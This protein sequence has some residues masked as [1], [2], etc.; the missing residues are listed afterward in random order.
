[1]L[2][3]IL[4][5]ILSQSKQTAK[6][7]QSK[8]NLRQIGLAIQVYATSYDDVQPYASTTTT[9]FA[10]FYG[11]RIY[12]DPYYSM[13][14]T[15]LLSEVLTLDRRIFRAPFDQGPVYEGSPS[16]FVSSWESIHLKERWITYSYADFPPLAAIP[17]SAIEPPAN[18]VLVSEISHQRRNP[19][20][21]TGRINCLFYDLSVRRE[22]WQTCDGS[23]PQ[24][25]EN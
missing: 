19:G 23:W 3:A 16:T 22:P 18:M 8:S 15:K 4:F 10:Q 1:M 17:M 6:I 7:T 13:L 11:I 2:A 5:P 20:F 24:A 21:A 9:L 25:P 14:S 12:P